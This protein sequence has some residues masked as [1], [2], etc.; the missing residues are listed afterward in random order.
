MLALRMLKVSLIRVTRLQARD[1]VM[2]AH[3]FFAALVLDQ[4]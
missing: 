3:T 4:A 2:T 1:A